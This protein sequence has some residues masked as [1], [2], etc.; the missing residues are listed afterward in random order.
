ML[1]VDVHFLTEKICEL[2]KEI[3][4]LKAEND[5]LNAKIRYLEGITARKRTVDLANDS[6]PAEVIKSKSTL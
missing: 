6:E 5:A 3:G 1:N 2:G 4:K